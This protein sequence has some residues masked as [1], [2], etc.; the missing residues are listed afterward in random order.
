VCGLARYPLQDEGAFDEAMGVVD[1][2]DF[3]LTRAALA[4]ENRRTEF[5]CPDS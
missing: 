2:S 4:A 3:T 1:H 5:L